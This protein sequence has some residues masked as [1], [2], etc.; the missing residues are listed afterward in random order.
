ME[1]VATCLPS[2]RK[3]GAHRSNS[4]GSNTDRN[5][6]PVT[7]TRCI[8]KL[9]TNGRTYHC[10][11]FGSDINC[12]SWDTDVAEDARK[13]IS[14][15][16]SLAV[17]SCCVPCAYKIGAFDVA[18]DTDFTRWYGKELFRSFRLLYYIRTVLARFL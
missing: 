15:K 18:L 11:L 13:I 5:K 2:S 17:A 3:R 6:I 12:G 8:D 7:V 14:N 16:A 4:T 9:Y 10:A 1:S